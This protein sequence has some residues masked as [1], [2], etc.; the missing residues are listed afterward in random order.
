MQMLFFAEL[1]YHHI[2]NSHDSSQG[3]YPYWSL[4]DPV[5]SVGRVAMV[6]KNIW[7]MKFFPG[8]GKVREYFG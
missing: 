7:K 4:A 2:G 3:S 6:R 8:Q 1:S 5:A